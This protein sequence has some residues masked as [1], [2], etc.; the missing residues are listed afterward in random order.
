VVVYVFNFK[1]FKVLHSTGFFT[2]I[3][4]FFSHVGFSCMA[5]I[6]LAARFLY[7]SI[8]AEGKAL[9]V[10]QSAPISARSLLMAKVRWGLTPMWLLSQA[11]TLTGAWLTDLS[12]V[13]LLAGAWASTLLTL[14]IVGLGVGLGAASPKFHLPNPMMV[15]SSLGGVSFM[16]LSLL[17]MVLFCVLAYPVVWVLNEGV[18]GAWPM[19]EGWVKSGVCLVGLHL[20]SVGAF[21]GAIKVG[22]RG[23]EAVLVGE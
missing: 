19:G 1:Y 18:Q 7:P 17:F 11:L 10:V 22:E 13:W 14:G 2:N 4:L 15:A 5:L 6:T 20:L 12:L 23:L 21:W 9:W 16:L 3:A 8:S